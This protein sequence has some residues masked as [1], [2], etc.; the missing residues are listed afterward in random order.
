M[1]KMKVLFGSLLITRVKSLLLHVQDHKA[2]ALTGW[3]PVEQPT[4]SCLLVNT[5]TMKN[6]NNNLLSQ[7][8]STV[9]PRFYDRRSNNIP[10]LTINILCPG[11]SYL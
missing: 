8:T 3:K 11:K 10:D 6:I 1:T 9:G 5:I 4:T 7:R 2:P